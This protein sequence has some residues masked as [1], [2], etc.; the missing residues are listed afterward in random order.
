MSTT[1][2][3]PASAATIGQELVG[4]CREGRNGDAIE[5]LYSKNIVSIEPMGSEAMPA[6]TKG[7]DAVHKKHAWW[8]ENMQ[9]HSAQVRGPF[10]G[11][12]EFAVYFD[13]DTTFKPTGQRSSMRE[14]ALYSVQNGEIVKE[15][16]FYKPSGG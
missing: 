2:S 4:L 16:F 8:T 10:V 5:R 13:Y 7:I 14:M 3:A 9:V 11:D 12:D 6:E 1:T 15:E